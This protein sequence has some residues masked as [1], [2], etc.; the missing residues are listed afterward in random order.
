MSDYELGAP[1]AHGGFGI[2]YAV[3]RQQ[4]G[5]PGV[6]KYLIQGYSPDDR[7]RFDREVRIQARLEHKNI[8]PIVHMDMG[9]DPPWFVMP[10]ARQN[11]RDYFQTANVDAR[12]ERFR[13]ALQGMVHAHDNGVIHRDLKPENILVFNGNPSYAAVGDFGLGRLIDRDTPTLTSTNIGMGT[14][15]YMAPEQYTNAKDADERS[16]VFSL[17]KILYEV[18]TLR[19]PYT[20]D[21]SIVQ[22]RRFVYVIQRAIN[23]DPDHRYQSVK[24]MLADVTRMM[25][26][27]KR[28]Q[29]LELVPNL[30]RRATAN[31]QLHQTAVDELL[32]CILD[33]T[34]DV[35]LLLEQLPNLPDVVIAA[36]VRKYPDAFKIILAAYDIQVESG[37]SFEYCDVVATFYEK[38]F[39]NTTNHDIKSLILKRLARLGA[40]NNRWYV[41]GVFGTIVNKLDDDALILEVVELLS[42]D[43][44]I[45]AFCQP[46]LNDGRCPKP[47]RDFYKN[48]S[49]SA[50]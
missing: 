26:D 23:P 21:L 34:D 18:L 36:L 1:I 28:Y 29:P 2:V 16:D 49:K 22:L 15:E 47:I 14:L 19:V 3:R 8:V 33:N 11:L 39:N 4:D 46:Y 13:E 25:D 24:E 27:W 43:S 44:R 48:R 12:L 10:R 40:W 20:V 42:K 50:S 5:W 41:G 45:A 35:K 32:Q 31:G 7:K 37:V 9:A 30:V 17:G 6:A 38:V